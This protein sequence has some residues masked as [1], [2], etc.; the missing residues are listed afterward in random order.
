M[1]PPEHLQLFSVAG[2]RV[3]LARA[4]LDERSIRTHAV[5][6]HEL[7]RGGFG[8]RVGG[9]GGERVQTGYRL[10]ESLSS[11]PLRRAVKRFV[12]EALNASRLGDSLKALA[13]KPPM[14]SR[15]RAH[16]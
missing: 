1:S 6:P 5:N 8:H 9:G 12:N 4:S 3:A 14:Q 7:L 13:E 15:S 2:L 16:T 11:G 10:N